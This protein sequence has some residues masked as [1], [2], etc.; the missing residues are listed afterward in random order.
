MS[1]GT[2]ERVYSE[3]TS[4]DPTPWIEKIAKSDSV[5]V[6]AQGVLQYWRHEEVKRL[7]SAAALSAPY[8]HILFDSM[9]PPL[10]HVNNKKNK[11]IRLCPDYKWSVWNTSRIGDG[12]DFR[13]DVIDEKNFMDMDKS[14]KEHMPFKDRIIY[15]APVI[16]NFYRMTFAQVCPA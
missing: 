7:F 16:R 2:G 3:S 9:A 10:V 4:T 8:V 5:I 6:I 12:E 15:G 13:V 1:A 11:T 14:V